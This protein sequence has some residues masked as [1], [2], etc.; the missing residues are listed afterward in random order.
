MFRVVLYAMAA[1]SSPALAQVPTYPP[2]NTA[3]LAAQ[4]SAA[5]TKADAA[6]TK[7][8]AAQARADAAVAAI[9]LPAIAPPLT[10]TMGGA[11]GT[12]TTRFAL[13]THKHPRITDTQIVTTVTGGTFSGTYPAGFFSIPP[14]VDLSWV[15]KGVLPMTC[16]L[17]ADPTVNGYQ[18]RCST[19]SIASILAAGA[20]VKV[21]VVTL[22]TTVP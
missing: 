7:A 3:A 22:P 18:G 4:A 21:H 1:L 10:D 11:I 16:E 5:Q 17:T 12:D 8:D 19:L 14:T 6:Q 2:A 20:G 15:N 9:P 13:A